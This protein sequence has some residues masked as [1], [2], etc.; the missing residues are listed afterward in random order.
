MHPPILRGLSVSVI[1]SSYWAGLLETEYPAFMPWLFQHD[2]YS[3]GV[4]P[5]NIFIILGLT[6]FAAGLFSKCTADHPHATP[7][8][9][10]LAVFMIF[11]LLRPNISLFVLATA[12]LPMFFWMLM[13]GLRLGAAYLFFVLWRLA[14]ALPL[15]NYSDWSVTG[16]DFLYLIL[17]C[18]G[19][20]GE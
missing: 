11:E 18:S 20:I 4:L 14:A 15:W 5:R 8:L 19:I 2:L 7:Q 10:C 6:W 1:C 9:P 17:A 13:R 3:A 12:L 16:V